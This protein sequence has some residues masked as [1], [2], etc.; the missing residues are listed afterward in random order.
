MIKSKAEPVKNRI[1]TV[2]KVLSSYSFNL[3]YIK[4]KDM[5]L[6]DLSTRQKFDDSDQHEVI[7]ISFNMQEVLNARYYNI[8]EGKQEKYLVHTR[9]QRLVVQCAKST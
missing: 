6:G 7:A 8:R 1:M 2:L 3:Y 9:A 5:I 4:R